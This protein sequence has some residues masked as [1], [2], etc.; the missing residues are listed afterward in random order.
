MCVSNDCGGF[1]SSVV[2]CW[3]LGR[4]ARRAGGLIVASQ[5]ASLETNRA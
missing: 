3:M 2:L 5:L 1:I 4:V